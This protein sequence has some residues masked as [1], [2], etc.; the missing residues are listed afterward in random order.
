MGAIDTTP[1][2]SALGFMMRSA[3]GVFAYGGFK[4]EYTN[5]T[6]PT[7]L[8]GIVYNDK[9]VIVGVGLNESIAY[10]SDL[11]SWTL[12]GSAVGYSLYGICYGVGKH[13]VCGANG[14]TAY[15][16]DG[17]TWTYIAFPAS[18]LV[19]TYITYE[20]IVYGDGLYVCVGGYY[21]GGF[22]VP[23]TYGVII[24]SSD[25]INWTL[26]NTGS[27]TYTWHG[28]CYGGGKYVIC[29][30]N[31]NIGYSSDAITWSYVTVGS[32]SYKSVCYGNGLFVAV[33]NNGKISYSSDAISWSTVDTGVNIWTSVAY[34]N[35]MY[36]CCDYSRSET[37]YSID[38]INWK[39][40]ETITENWLSISYTN[41]K[42]IICG[43][44]GN[45]G[46]KD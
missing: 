2:R 46:Y 3:L 36:V 39:I 11:N 8:N 44:N 14:L 38:A 34:G 21:K 22:G 37:A 5:L 35:G 12:V 20:D 23:V 26:I 41:N 10:S 28:I 42:F 45:I 4:W 24:Y 17:I 13:V 15:S 40:V 33:G 7:I 6:Q 27:S 25:G 16:S 31:G 43:Q 19:R 9:Y 29:G 18:L 30:D 32:D 1:G